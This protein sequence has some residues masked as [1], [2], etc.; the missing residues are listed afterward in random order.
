MDERR[1]STGVEGLDEILLGGLIR[2][3]S[4]LVRGGP[5]TGK[6]TLG[7]HFLAE[8][9]ARGE[10]CLFISLTESAQSIRANAASM[11]INLDGVDFLDLSPPPEFFVQVETYDLF[12]PAEVEREPMTEQIVTRIE[13]IKPDR[14]FV[15]SMSQFRYLAADPFQY[16]KQV[17]SFLRFLAD[18]N[19]TVMFTSESSREAPDEDLQFLSDGVLNLEAGAN[20]RTA[21]ISKLRGT[22]YQGGSHSMTVSDQGMRVFPRLQPAEFSREFTVEALSSGVPELDELLHG[23]LERG[24]TTII[25][26]PSGVGKTTLGLLFMKE[27]AGRGERSVV[28]SFEEEAEVIKHR[29]EAISIPVGNMIER[30]TLDIVKVEPLQYTPDEF[31]LLVRRDVE[32][33]GARIIM[34]DSIAGYKL[35]LRGGHLVSHL[36]ALVKYLSNMGVTVLV[37]TEVEVIAGGDFRVTDVGISY[38]ADNVIFFRY[39]ELNGELHKALGVLKKRLS[40]FERAMRGFE[41][42]HHGVKVGAPL[43]GL[44][45]ILTGIP[46]LVEH[47]SRGRNDE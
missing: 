29:S 1:V 39:L 47:G 21:R 3:N 28:Y 13:E 4:Y 26:G 31:G 2:G 20:N 11:H 36:H 23:G 38:L 43:T 24:T 35:S 10:R 8:G 5:G 7:L 34:L 12:S 32:E 18:H 30:G 37:I 19:A 40:G 16:R 14:V 15:D 44:R 6:T 27:A 9:V 25:S 17:V 45:G 33:K 46:D 42:T 41:I 22:G